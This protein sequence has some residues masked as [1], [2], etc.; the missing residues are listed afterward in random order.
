MTIERNPLEFDDTLEE[1]LRR[2]AAILELTDFAFPG[3]CHVQCEA[4]DV[5]DR[6]TIHIG[7]VL[8][9]SFQ[10]LIYPRL[11]GNETLNFE[12]DAENNFL[13]L[14]F[15]FPTEEWPDIFPILFMTTAHEKVDKITPSNLAALLTAVAD[16]TVDGRSYQEWIS[17]NMTDESSNSS[18][19]STA[20]SGP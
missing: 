15:D 4:F 10:E 19:G 11:R 12:F 14:H 6:L 18:D 8:P 9:S 20:S 13:V 16:G 7:N 3:S 1:K 5:C 2:I 17:T